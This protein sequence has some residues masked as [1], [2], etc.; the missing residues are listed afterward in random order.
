MRTRAYRR[1]VRH[2][3]ICRKKGIVLA[4]DGSGWYKFDGQYSKGKIF[5]DC[6]ICK[7]CRKWGLETIK[8]KKEREIV[9]YA[10]ND[11]YSNR[12]GA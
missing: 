10:F 2:K 8:M 11:Y 7:P 1:N 4:R 5:C 3:A 6:G 9:E 12:K